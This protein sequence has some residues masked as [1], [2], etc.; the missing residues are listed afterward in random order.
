MTEKAHL[1]LVSYVTAALGS[2]A[3]VLA[4]YSYARSYDPW[5]T[6]RSTHYMIIWL[7]VRSA[8]LVLCFWSFLIGLPLAIF[9]P[10]LRRSATMWASLAVF[11]VTAFVCLSAP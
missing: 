10:N 8:F 2:F 3:I 7:N 6:L 1:V 11:A 4:A 9:E 5:F